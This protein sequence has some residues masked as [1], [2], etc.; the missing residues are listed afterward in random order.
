[1]LF[2]AYHCPSWKLESENRLEQNKTHPQSRELSLLQLVDVGWL[3]SSSSQ[4]LRPTNAWPTNM[5]LLLKGFGKW[6][7]LSALVWDTTV[8]LNGKDL[9]L[10]LIVLSTRDISTSFCF[11][12]RS[13]ETGAL[14][15]NGRFWKKN[16]KPARCSKTRNLPTLPRKLSSLSLPLCADLLLVVFIAYVYL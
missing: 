14:Q 8:S 10:L 5:W 12:A 15:K 4:S 11:S 1:M 13:S 6:F 7:Y 9:V 3:A 16:F 2:Q